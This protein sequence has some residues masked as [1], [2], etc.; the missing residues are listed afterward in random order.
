MLTIM[1]AATL[2]TPL[3]NALIAL[4]F[5]VYTTLLGYGIV[6]ANPGNPQ[7][8]STWRARWGTQAR[9]GGPLLVVAGLVLTARALAWF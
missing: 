7:K 4:A 9:I 6:P 8:S 2:S 5:G 3:I 1:L